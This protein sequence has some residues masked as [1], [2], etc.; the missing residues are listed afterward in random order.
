[1]HVNESEEGVSVIEEDDENLSFNMNAVEAAVREVLPA[2]DYNC[3]LSSL[4]YSRSASSNKPMWTAILEVE[5]GTYTG[6]KIWTIMS[7]S[8][9]AI[10]ITKG[11]IKTF[12]PEVLTDDF[13]PKKIADNGD[14][15]GKKCRVRTK[16]E[17]YEGE[18]QCRVKRWM[19]PVQSASAFV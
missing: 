19:A 3:V 2:G 6:K 11:A 15:L 17:L 1:M 5:D 8:E 7:F 4:D 18:K 16:I 12:A 13:Q 14:L 10:A 9:K